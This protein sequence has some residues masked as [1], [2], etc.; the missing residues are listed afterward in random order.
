MPA[1]GTSSA[2]SLP[3]PRRA[4][5]IVLAAVLIDVVGFSMVMPV[6][7]ALVTRFGHLDLAAAMRVA[8]S[9]LAVFALFQFFA[10]SVLGNLGDRFGRRSVPIAT[11]RPTVR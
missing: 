3:P 7:P 10:G 5:P 2:D 4:V 9:M 11:M 6:L 1:D 8:G